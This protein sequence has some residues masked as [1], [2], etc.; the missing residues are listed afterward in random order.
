M[1]TGK[2]VYGVNETLETLF[3]SAVKTLI[4]WEELEIDRYLLRNNQTG[5]ETELHLN[6]EQSAKKD[7]SLF[8]DKETGFELEIVEQISLLEWLA[9]NYIKFGC[10]L[11]FITDRSQEGSQFCKGFGGIG[12][13]LRFKPEF[14]NPVVDYDDG[15]WVDDDDFDDL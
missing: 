11:E 9:N 6:K 7:E 13:I 2:Y 14:L 3:G 10:E 8:R 1:D 4:V 15:E 12:G 5:E